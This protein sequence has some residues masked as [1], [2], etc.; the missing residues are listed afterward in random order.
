MAENRLWGE[1]CSI[2]NILFVNP[3]LLQHFAQTQPLHF[4][5][6][7]VLNDSCTLNLLNIL[8]IAKYVKELYRKLLISSTV[9]EDVITH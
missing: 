7:H 6:R 8:H 2:S 9:Y 5:I 4:E 1:V 3:T